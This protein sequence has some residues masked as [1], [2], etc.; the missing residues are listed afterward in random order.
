MLAETILGSIY[1]PAISD[2]PILISAAIE[3]LAAS[4]NKDKLAAIQTH[5]FD[6]GEFCQLFPLILNLVLRKFDVAGFQKDLARATSVDAATTTHPWNHWPLQ[7]L[8]S[9]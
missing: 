3:R 6:A 7:P 5:V 4:I 1:L 9:T 8:V 2:A